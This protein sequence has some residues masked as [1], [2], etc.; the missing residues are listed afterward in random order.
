MIE[1]INIEYLGATGVGVTR[2]GK[3]KI[4]TPYVLEGEVVKVEVANQNS[5]YINTKLVEVVKESAHR[6]TPP[7]EYFYKCGG[8]LLQH[9]DDVSYLD[10]KR[11][12][13]IESLSRANISFEENL[14]DPIIVGSNARRRASFRADLNSFGFYERS[15]NKIVDIKKC[16]I[17][18]PE[19]NKLI[20]ELHKLVKAF[21]P[22]LLSRGLE[23]DIVFASVGSELFIKSELL[24]NEQESKLIADFNHVTKVSWSHNGQIIN[25]IIREEPQELFGEYLV[26]VPTGEFLQPTKVAEELISD[27]ILGFAK[28]K[29]HILDL[30]AGSGTYSFRI[31]KTAK[32]TAMEGNPDMVALIKKTAILYCLDINAYRRD[33]YLYPIDDLHKYDMIVINPP[34]NGAEP[35]IN[36]IAK[37]N[38]SSVIMVSCNPKTFSRDAKILSDGGYKLD[39]IIAIDQF[40]YTQHLEIVAHFIKGK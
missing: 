32:V 11:K 4:F 8:C 1:E 14:P 34:R 15:S 20:P 36:H 40:H 28:T 6:V 3:K 25:L 31:A 23:I 7:C 38:V 24:P 19:I 22:E 18:T 30:Y 26:P 27:F 5:K 12:I 16:L 17:L 10:F 39:K 21:S 9:M 13:F 33:L 37:S 2:S 29:T 35:Q